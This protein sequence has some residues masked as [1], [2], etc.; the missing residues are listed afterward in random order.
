MLRE[1]IRQGRN[2]VFRGQCAAEYAIRRPRSPKRGY[3]GARLARRWPRVTVKWE[4]SVER[5]HHTIDRVA[6]QLDS[7]GVPREPVGTPASYVGRLSWINQADLVDKIPTT[8]E[9]TLLRPEAMPNEIEELCKA[10]REYQFF[11]VCVQPVYAR[12]AAVLLRGTGCSVVA[13]IGF[14]HGSNTSET[15]AFE[16]SGAIGRDRDEPGADDID[17]PLHPCCRKGDI[18]PFPTWRLPG[19]A[20]VRRPYRAAAPFLCPWWPSTRPSTSGSGRTRDRRCRPGRRC[21][22]PRR[23]PCP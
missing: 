1:R 2:S 20:G 19:S 7:Y 6:A 8:L 16:A 11:G 21:P 4:I 15:K 23:P 22:R 17:Q 10:A 9:H 18:L 12:R 5:L 14:P 13:V 3:N